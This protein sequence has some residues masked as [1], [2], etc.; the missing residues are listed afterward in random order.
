MVRRDEI[1]AEG[2]EERNASKAEGRF[3][4]SL[5]SHPL[6]L[7]VWRRSDLFA[8]QGDLGDLSGC[9]GQHLPTSKV[10]TRAGLGAPRSNCQRLSVDL[11]RAGCTFFMR[12][13]LASH[14]KTR[15]YDMLFGGLTLN[16]GLLL[17]MLEG[18]ERW[19]DCVERIRKHSRIATM[20]GSLR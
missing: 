5:L 1:P 18:T 19:S 10:S 14:Q 15:Y 17:M 20:A 12:C 2:K 16:F 6:D 4:W 11:H 13:I 8:Q 3:A 7:R 9:R